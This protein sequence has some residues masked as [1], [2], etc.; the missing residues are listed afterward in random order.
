MC[1]WRRTEVV[2]QVVNMVL[3]L[4]A[5]L[6]VEILCGRARVWARVRGAVCVHVCGVR[7]RMSRH[8]SRVPREPNRAGLACV[9]GT[10]PPPKR[11]LGAAHHNTACTHNR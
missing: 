5:G 4:A 7:A 1:A 11:V 2:Q 10:Q 3:F 6:V 9:T 8:K